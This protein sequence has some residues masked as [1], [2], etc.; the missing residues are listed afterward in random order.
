MAYVPGESS[1]R[2]SAGT[3]NLEPI[4]K[5][6]QLIWNLKG[7]ATA[8]HYVPTS[9]DPQ[10]SIYSPL[11]M[12][13]FGGGYA[14][15]EDYDAPLEPTVNGNARTWNVDS[16]F[17]LRDEQY[18]FYGE[19]YPRL[20]FT[21]DAVLSVLGHDSHLNTGVNAPIPTAA[22][23]NNLIA[24]LWGD[25]KVV[26]D[27]AQGTG[28]RLGTMGNGEI[29]IVEYDG[30]QSVGT[31]GSINV[32]AFISRSVNPFAP[33]IVF[34]YERARGVLPKTVTGLENATGT[35]GVAHK[36]QAGGDGLV[37]CYDW[38]ADEIMLDYSTKVT[39]DATVDSQLT[40]V[41]A[42]SLSAPATK[43]TTQSNSVF[44]SGVVLTVDQDGPE[45]VSPGFP[46]TYTLTVANKGK[47]AA[48]NVSVLAQ[49][50]LGARYVA[51]GTLMPSSIVSFTLPS[52]AAGAQVQLPYSFVLNDD[53]TQL[54]T[55]EM[56]TPDI[57]GGDVAADGA[58]PWQAALWDNKWDGWYGCGGSLIA[59]GW[60]LTAAHCVVDDEGEPLVKPSRLS[61]LLGVN[62]LSK[63][64]NGQRI[65]VAEITIH[66]QYGLVTAFDSDLALLRLASPAQ[67]NKKVQVVPLATSF[68]A[69]LF[70]ANR[71]ATVTGW[72]TRTSEEDD[73]PDKLYQVT[74]PF[75]DQNACAFGYAAKDDVVTENM[76]CAGLLEGGKDSC[77]GDSG[78]P[79]VVR[80]P[81]GKWKQAGVVSWGIGC[82][83]PGL[84]GLYTRLANFT[85]YISDV[86][87]TLTSRGFYAT[88]GTGLP[89]HFFRGESRISTLVKPIRSYLPIIGKK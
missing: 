38:K 73:Y 51:G 25:F 17:G 81:N 62:D 19:K 16:F 49:L 86:Q 18:S 74:V 7:V 60:V 34:A 35:Q 9:S 85:S 21:D 12:T 59:P 32:E 46:I 72:G 82:G 36:G 77:Q 5:G 3:V 28:V 13:P 57:I 84:P 69:A 78:G 88:D 50:P 76:L 33:E 42:S 1:L 8:P 52:L 20:F 22:L 37:L 41:V 26:Y 10:S 6:N 68:D 67:L 45:R 54:Q 48:K 29:M 11:C 64:E 44:V 80:A 65:Q 43:A 31:K 58:W 14:H 89:G 61:V 23:P 56:Q 40:T 87:N 66:P 47:G 15:L 39:A 4:V 63:A 2:T 30:L 55:A 24:P 53:N 27:E 79:M 83:L 71:A 70:A 75:V